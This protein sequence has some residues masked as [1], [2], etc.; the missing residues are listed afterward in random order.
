MLRVLE[1][2]RRRDA[3]HGLFRTEKQHLRLLYQ[4]KVD[5]FLRALSR[6]LFEQIA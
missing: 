6:F 4:L 3:V 5:V 1:A 2:Q